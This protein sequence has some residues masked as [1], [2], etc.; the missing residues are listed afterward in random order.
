MTSAADALNALATNDASQG[1]GQI[2]QRVTGVF[3][4]MAIQSDGKWLVVTMGSG[5]IWPSLSLF[6]FNADGSLDRS[7]G[8][9]EAGSGNPD[10]PLSAVARPV[11]VV[12]PESGDLLVLGANSDGT[13]S[14][15]RL[16]ADGTVDEGFG[17]DGR[18]WNIGLDRGWAGAPKGLAV[19]GDGRILLAA[20]Q[21]DGQGGGSHFMV[22]RLLANGERDNSF[23][24]PGGIEGDLAAF[25]QLSDGRLLL[26]GSRTVEGKSVPILVRLQADGRPDS[27]WGADAREIPVEGF[28]M[29]A[30]QVQADGRIVLVGYVEG[31][32]SEGADSRSVAVLRLLA[33]GRLDPTFNA[34]GPTPGFLYDFGGG[35]HGLS[36]V[37]FLGPALGLTL[38]ATGD[39]LLTAPGS[40]GFTLVRID[41]TGQ[42]DVSLN[43]D[44]TTPGRLDVGVN[45]HNYYGA[46]VLTDAEGRIVFGS[47]QD[48]KTGGPVFSNVFMGSL[49]PDG[50]LDPAFGIPVDAITATHSTDLLPSA[51][52]A[53][54]DGYE[55]LDWVEFASR[56]A[57]YEVSLS[58]SPAQ[59][60]QVKGPDGAVQL[61]DRIE[62]LRFEDGTVLAQGGREAQALL[63]VLYGAEA[64]QSPFLLGLLNDYVDALGLSS[65]LR[66][67]EEDGTLAAQLGPL[68]SESMLRAV[69]GNVVGQA[70]DEAALT[71]LREQ[72]HL[73]TTPDSPA[74]QSLSYLL[75]SDWLTQEVREQTPGGIV[76]YQS[77]EGVVVGTDG[78]DFLR[79]VAGGSRLDGGGGLDTV[80]LDAVR[81][82]YVIE[83]AEDG[84]LV[85]EG[86][87]HGRAELL[88]AERLRFADTALAFDLAHDEAAGQAVRLLTVLGCRHPAIWLAKPLRGWIGWVR[89]AQRERSLTVA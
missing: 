81:S 70:H 53:R 23:I 67:L 9:N 80:Q 35:L 28:R 69:Y 33:D 15:V 43:P 21:A 37:H 79:A 56:R 24:A 52:V 82:R 49:L 25:A 8:D 74:W 31:S 71:A 60:W 2:V 13:L 27:S 89:K 88:N 1:S 48:E 38:D 62:Y 58:G 11:L 76:A 84:H 86:G 3:A 42:L 66:M 72:L 34:E 17:S 41:A 57:D 44:G 65:V 83:Q 36:S 78:A 59:Q 20:S 73:Y 54:I 5:W 63:H 4:Q 26:A 87:S 29:E 68:D 61:L 85:V 55:G 12:D 14:L 64:V 7:F 19:T 6:R 32:P 18:V 77:F 75:W 50:S 39:I 45:D 10:L 22:Q 40:T 47:T 16:N 46:Q 51:S 30:M